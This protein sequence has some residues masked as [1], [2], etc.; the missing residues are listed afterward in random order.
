MRSKG[1]Y[2]IFFVLLAGS[3]VMLLPILYMLGMSFDGKAILNIPFPPSLFPKEPSVM[4]YIIAFTNVPL[5]RYLLNSGTVSTGVILVSGISAL[6]AGYSLSKIKFKGSKFVFILALS[7]MMIPFEM[8]MIPQY[9]LFSKLRLTNSYLAF[10]L[11]AVNY[12]F[13]TFL[14]KQFMDS[15][16]SSLREAAKIDGASEFIIFLKVYFPLCINIITTLVILIF[17]GSWNDFLWPLIILNDPI[18]YTIQIGAAMFTYDQGANLMPAIRMVISLVS[19][20]PILFVF[21]FLQRY[22]MESI[23]SSGIKQ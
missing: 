17:L 14:V 3:V 2:I 1:D 12:A 13:G 20:A 15:L 10:Y 8:T 18:K 19:V 23:A 11:P 4:P 16:P 9:L 7:T 6:A 21:L 22:I 5:F